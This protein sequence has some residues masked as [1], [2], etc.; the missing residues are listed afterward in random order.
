MYNEFIQW[1]FSPELRCFKQEQLTIQRLNQTLFVTG[2]ECIS[3][4]LW[5]SNYMYLKLKPTQKNPQKTNQ[6]THSK[7]LQYKECFIVN[8][9]TCVIKK[10][11]PVECY[12]R[13]QWCNNVRI[14]FVSFCRH[15][16]NEFFR[17]NIN[18]PLERRK[19]INIWILKIVPSFSVFQNKTYWW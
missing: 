12:T 16:I 17:E 4:E 15:P 13:V 8:T 7:T 11:K 19:C 5:K 2:V 18:T 6:K 3:V 1:C 9:Y 10:V 14:S